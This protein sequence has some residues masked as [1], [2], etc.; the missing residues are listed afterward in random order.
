MNETLQYESVA[1]AGKRSSY[2]WVICG[3]LFFALTIN[4][5]D[6]QVIGVR[7]PILGKDFGW[8]Q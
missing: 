1:V 5:I 8:R 2:R 7:K 4:Y 6:R 3:M